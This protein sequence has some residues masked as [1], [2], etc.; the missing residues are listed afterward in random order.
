MT[1]MK[2]EGGSGEDVGRKGPLGRGDSS[3]EWTLV[4]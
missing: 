1:L 2:D 4:N 3:L